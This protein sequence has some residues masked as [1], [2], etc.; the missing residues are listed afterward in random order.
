MDCSTPGFPVLH[1]L[2]ESL[3]KLMLT[4]SV[5]PFKH[6]IPPLPRSPPTFNFSQ[7]QSFPM[8]HLFASGGLGIG[9]SASVLPM[10]IQGWFP[11]RVDWFDL[12]AV[13]ETLKSLQHHISKASIHWCSAFFIVQ[14]S[15][16]Y[17]TTEK[18]IALIM[19]TFVSKVMSLLSDILGL[20]GILDKTS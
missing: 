11:V 3:L 7:H 10:N 1:Y 2:P 5:M 16:P 8:S 18:M 6:P 17:M 9:V 14:L 19:W 15:D 4:E 13:Q 20:S 12:L